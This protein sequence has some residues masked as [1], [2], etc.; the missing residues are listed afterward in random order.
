MGRIQVRNG[1]QKN[2]SRLFYETPHNNRFLICRLRAELTI[3][4]LRSGDG[5]QD[6]RESLLRKETDVC[7]RMDFCIKVLSTLSMI[8]V[9]PGASSD[10]LLR[11]LGNVYGTLTVL[12]KYFIAKVGKHNRPLQGIR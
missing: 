5:S 11:E 10:A 4:P 12:T 3:S 1:K 6:E 8:A 7:R 2:M 9:P